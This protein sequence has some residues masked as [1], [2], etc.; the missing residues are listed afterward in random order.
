MQRMSTFSCAP[1]STTPQIPAV[2]WQDTD[3]LLCGCRIS[4]PVIEAPD[5]NDPDGGLRFAVV[6]CVKCGLCFTNPRPDPG[7]IGQFYPALYAPHQLRRRARTGSTP[8]WLRG[9]HRPRRKYQFIGWRGEGRLLDFGCGGGAFLARMHE[10]GWQ[11]TGLDV[12][13]TA[14]NR[15]REELRLPAFL[16]TLP[17]R[18][19]TPSSFD[20]VTMW[21]ALEHVHAPLEVLREAHRLLVPEGR[22]YVAV[23]NI[24]SLPFR[25]FGA[26]W[27]GLDLPRHLTHFSP[28]TLRLMLENAGFSVKSI[29][30]VRHSD[31]LRNSAKRA[32]VRR[33]AGEAGTE[34][35]GIVPPRPGPLM[36]SWRRWLTHKPC[37]RLATWYAYLRK[38]TDCITAI[39]E[40]RSPRRTG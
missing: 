28:S 13:P 8:H 36:A 19:L 12:S 11:V 24:D 29:R 10:E 14:V 5:P 30:M 31:W 34:R 21:Q 37:S 32:T 33:P 39:G 17:H 40:K 26:S 9:W 22:L 3:C 7:S 20:V 27:Y 2:H 16:G 18:N 35:G 25:W 6:Q 15:V 38:Q 4:R 1:A 23:P